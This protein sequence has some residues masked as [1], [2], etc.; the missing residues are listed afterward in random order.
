MET[1]IISTE[2]LQRF[3]SFS[4]P[5]TT[6]GVIYIVA[7]QSFINKIPVLSFLSNTGPLRK[8][9]TRSFYLG[10]M[11]CCCSTLRFHRSCQIWA[12]W[13][14]RADLQPEGA[15]RRP[16]N[17]QRYTLPAP[18]FEKRPPGGCWSLA[19]QCGQTNWP[20]WSP[21]G[22]PAAG[23]CRPPGWSWAW[24]LRSA[25]RW[26]S[27][28]R[29]TWWGCWGSWTCSWWWSWPGRPAGQRPAPAGSRSSCT[30]A[31]R[32]S[33]PRSSSTG[34]PDCSAHTQTDRKKERERFSHL[35]CQSGYKSHF[36]Q[37]QSVYFLTVIK[38]MSLHFMQLCTLILHFNGK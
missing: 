4:P 3:S 34:P 29:R 12:C 32:Y 28:R 24:R 16:P 17:P 1:F 20:G 6:P 30:A 33:A 13:S 22:R 19:Q 21:R 35:I 7:L 23:R 15:A 38:K 25:R 10:P 31:G 9:T 5:Q 26:W 27:R 8:A 11:H 2:Y 37:Y 36:N 14:S 18:S